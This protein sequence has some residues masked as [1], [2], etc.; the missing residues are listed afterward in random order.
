MQAA[1]VTRHCSR[2]AVLQ[3]LQGTTQRIP[4]SNRRTTIRGLQRI[5][6][7]GLRRTDLAG[8]FQLRNHLLLLVGEL[9]PLVRQRLEPF[10]RGIQRLP[11]GL[12]RAGHRC[13]HARRHIH[14]GLHGL[15]ELLP[16]DIGV[17]QQLR[18]RL[19]DFP[20]REHAR[21]RQRCGHAVEPLL[22]PT[23]SL[24]GGLQH[25]GELGL[26]LLGVDGF[27][28]EFAKERRRPLR[29]EAEHH[30]GGLRPTLG[31]AVRVFLLFLHRR[32]IPGV[33]G[34]G[35]LA[36]LLHLNKGFGE[37]LGIPDAHLDHR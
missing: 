21:L 30:L 20:R 18:L 17:S 1:A 15:R 22:R 25:G 35:N 4:C 13:A 5:Q 16:H 36:R 6:D 34:E 14:H 24:A 12:R 26:L 23:R 32:Q 9:H 28:N 2:K 29:Q 33:G 11:D 10:G 8:C 37:A 3:R 7:N 27:R 31:S 19:G